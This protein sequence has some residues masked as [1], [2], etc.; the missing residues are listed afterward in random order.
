[1]NQHNLNNPLS[2]EIQALIKLGKM[3]FSTESKADFTDFSTKNTIDWDKLY[4]LARF[5]QIR[6]LILRGVSLLPENEKPEAV[7]IKLKQDCQHLAFHGLRQTAELI[8]LLNLY[9]QHNILA[10]PYKGVWLANTYYGDWSM[11]EFSDIDIFVYEKD[12][13]SIKK[14]M[15]NEGYTP[16]LILTNA[17]E[18]MMMH[19]LCEYNFDLFNKDNNRLFHIEPHYKSNGISDGVSHLTLY[20][21]EQRLKEIPFTNTTIKCFSVEDNLLLMV[22]H[23]GMKEGWTLLK[24]LFDIYAVLK[25]EEN[26]IDWAYISSKVEQLKIKKPL[27][28]GLYLIHH[29]FDMRFPDY[30]LVQIQQ[31]K[32]AILAHKRYQTLAKIK[33]K[34]KGFELFFFNL[35]CMETWGDRVKISV[36]RLFY[37]HAEDI[38]F[39]SLAP[40]LSFL[41]FFLRPIRGI[42]KFV[43]P[44]KTYAEWLRNSK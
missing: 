25:K 5:H 8:R 35:R 13:F 28:I 15:L 9:K 26:V 4:D 20:D 31:P 33:D 22:I 10:I 2:T 17:Q 37:P 36:N 11:R 38:H 40:H 12:I 42:L 34:N 21:F 43:L 24:Y 14:I 3:V 27:F 23:H 6:P 7:L 1:M 41:Y 32:I 44:Q 29:L 19:I 30:I 39:L 18:K 16:Q